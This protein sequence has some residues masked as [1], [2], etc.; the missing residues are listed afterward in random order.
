[1]LIVMK[2]GGTSVGSAD[3][4]AQ[5]ARLVTDQ[6]SKGHRVAVVTSAISGVTNML[7][8]TA[9]AASKGQWDPAIRRKLFDIHQAAAVTLVPDEAGRKTVLAEIERRLD[10]FEKLC[11][12]LSMVH[13]LTPR[14]LDAISG[15]GE[16]LAAP[17][18]A[19][20]IRARACRSEA[21]D[22]TEILVTTDQ[23]GGAEP[24]MDETR[25]RTMAR[26]GPMVTH[27]DAP[28]V[29]GFIGATIDGVQ[30]T[31]GRGGS[32]YSASILGV[33][34]DADE[35]WIWTDVDGV[36]TANPSEVAAARTLS[37]ISYSEASELAYYG[38]KV[39]HY[40]TI[41]PAFRKRIPVRI[42]N[43]FN[44]SH[45]GTRVSVEGDPSVPGVKAVTSIRGVSLIGISGTGMQGIP[46]IVAKAFDVVAEQQSNVLMI[47]QASSEN[48]IC[49][50]ISASEAPGVLKA[51]KAAL[52]FELARGH[53]E[54]I[55]SQPVAVV[56]A[57]G[58]R[59]RGTPGIA[60]TVFGA[61][62]AE[63]INVIAISQ[64]SSERNISFVVEEG[65]AAA[66][67][68]ALHQAFRLDQTGV[69]PA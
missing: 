61:L 20:A 55:A 62:G 57:I 42:L 53:I 16:M 68:R 30:T 23:F 50:V 27:G 40:K 19:A 65:D 51:L 39:L 63:R 34:L 12:G 3:R 60:A 41:L 36:M 32:D 69:V 28:V 11:F 46:G 8:D 66:A 14:L 49:F 52:E 24:L 64:G 29:T 18:V 4:I 54:E 35:V 15:I 44:P 47:S 58:D 37:E 1:M 10:R 48:N 9:R 5:A 59:M 22:A 45:P 43:S 17:L 56:A 13:E 7:I 31:L 38:A 21:I 2:F 67:V 25:A 26:L 33:A 6:L